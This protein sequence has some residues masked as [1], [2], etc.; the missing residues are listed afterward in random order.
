M[1]RY[2]TLD[3]KREEEL[4]ALVREVAGDACRFHADGPQIATYV[5]GSIW[6]RGRVKEHPAAVASALAA[7]AIA[8]DALRAARSSLYL[9]DFGGLWVQ[10]RRSQEMVTLAVA[11]SMEPAIAD[12]WL[13]GKEVKQAPLRKLIEK[14]HP[15]LATD[16]WTSYGHLSDEAHGR[17]H[18]ALSAYEDRGERFSWPVE[19][20]DVNRGHVW[21]AHVSYCAYTLALLG[22]LRWVGRGN[23]SFL[24]PEFRP[25]VEI[26]YE[27]LSKY[28][29]EAQVGGDWRVLAPT[30]VRDW[31]MDA[32]GASVE[33]RALR[34]FDSPNARPDAGSDGQ[35]DGHARRQQ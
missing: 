12:Q 3:E 25:A 1:R 13:A 28:M 21:S 35:S 7:M 22:V 8:T 9:C 18:V 14:T 31:L 32:Y 11:L 16:L 15:K 33:E 34:G 24:D 2:P 5:I 10:I 17:A 4:A 6:A 23:W 20:V 26:Y 27:S 19:A 30:E 29:E